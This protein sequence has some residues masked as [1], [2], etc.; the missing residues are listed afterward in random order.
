M[1]KS[2]GIGCMHSKG[3]SCYKPLA[4]IAALQF[5]GNLDCNGHEYIIFPKCYYNL[6]DFQLKAYITLALH[7]II[8][9]KSK[10]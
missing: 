7:C 3:H 9:I 8:K 6:C 10:I 5:E 1:I 2:L 4:L